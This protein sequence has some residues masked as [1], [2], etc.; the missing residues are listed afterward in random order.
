[1]NS[2]LNISVYGEDISE[3]SGSTSSAEMGFQ[4]AGV[5]VSVLTMNLNYAYTHYAWNKVNQLAFDNGDDAP[6][7][8]VH[9]LSVSGMYGGVLTGRCLYA[10]LK[11]IAV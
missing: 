7:E 5:S 3:P 6:W 1:M 11:A 10:K 2:L 8:H 9:L 4:Q